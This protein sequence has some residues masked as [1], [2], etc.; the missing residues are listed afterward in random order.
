M[1]LDLPLEPAFFILGHTPENLLSKD[2]KYLLEMLLL[3][4]KKM[5]TVSWRNV[6]PPTVQ[7]W[8]IRLKNVYQMEV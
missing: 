5:I 6:N 2:Q 7:Q 1:A 3:I 4:A 8:R